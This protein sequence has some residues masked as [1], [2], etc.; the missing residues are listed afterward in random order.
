M[1]SIL[2]SIKRWWRNHKWVDTRD[3]YILP[4]SY[5]VFWLNE[6]QVQRAKD[7]KTKNRTTFYQYCFTPG[8]IGVC[9]NIRCKVGES[10]DITDYDVW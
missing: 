10:E 5:D 9:C 4:K 2:T 6:K 8:P 7:Y 1:I 3:F